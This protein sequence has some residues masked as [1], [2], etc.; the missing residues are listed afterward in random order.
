MVVRDKRELVEMLRGERS[1][2]SSG[3]IKQT[4]GEREAPPLQGDRGAEGQEGLYHELQD[5]PRRAFAHGLYSGFS[6]LLTEKKAALRGSTQSLEDLNPENILKR[7]Y[8]ITVRS[9]TRAVVSEADQ[10][11]QGDRVSVR[12]HRGGLDCVV[13]KTQP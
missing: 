12:L 4:A 3:L 13:E 1:S 8:S 9:D 11:G 10:V 7:G 2:G 6:A 5:V